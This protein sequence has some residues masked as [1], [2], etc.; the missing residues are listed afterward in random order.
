MATEHNRMSPAGI[1]THV[2][3]TALG[4]AAD[5]IPVTLS[6]HEGTGLTEVGSGRTG[7]DG[8]I[9]NLLGESVLA[10]GRYRLQYDLAAY[11]GSRQHLFEQVTFDLAITEVRHHHVPLLIGPFSC[12]SYRGT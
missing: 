11:F 9:A 12:S 4:V 10:V 2:L 6:R 1:S 3:D 5:G 8:R 7:P